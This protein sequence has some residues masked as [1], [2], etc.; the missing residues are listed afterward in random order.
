[1]EQALFAEKERADVTLNSIGD[2]VVSTDVAG[3]ITYLNLAAERMTGW[4]RDDASGRPLAEVFHIVD[5]ATRET[6]RDPMHLAVLQNKP[7]A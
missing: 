7:W 4:S 5:G 3:N 1:V 2:A 6:A